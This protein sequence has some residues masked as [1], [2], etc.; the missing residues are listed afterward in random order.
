M[1]T[2]CY[3][4]KSISN[5]DFI[6]LVNALDLVHCAALEL[7]LSILKHRYYFLGGVSV[8]E[9]VIVIVVV[10]SPKYE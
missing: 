2:H 5:I 1:I 9:H 7:F 6:N 10:I 4:N 3:S 8:Y